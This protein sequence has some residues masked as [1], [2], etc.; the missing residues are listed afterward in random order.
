VTGMAYLR[1]ALLIVLVLPVV[2]LPWEG[3]RPPLALYIALAVVGGLFAFV[4]SDLTGAMT[5]IAAG[6]ICLCALSVTLSSVRSRTGRQILTGGQ[7]KLLSS[8]AVWLGMIGSLAMI[9]LAGLGLLT[10]A[11]VHRMNGIARR[12]DS[13]AIVAGTIL[14]VGFGQLMLLA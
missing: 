2:I 14:C 11:V 6:I 12:P 3:R 1:F 4:C 8:G 13:G 9:I 10:V 5:N 7:I